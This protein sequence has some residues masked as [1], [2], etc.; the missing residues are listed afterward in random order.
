MKASLNL[1]ITLGGMFYF[2]ILELFWPKHK[3]EANMSYVQNCSFY[4]MKIQEEIFGSF[5]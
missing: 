2:S 5:F 1:R 3:C 4:E